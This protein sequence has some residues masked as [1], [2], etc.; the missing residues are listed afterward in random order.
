MIKD[1]QMHEPHPFI[2]MSS[3]TAGE[4]TIRLIISQWSCPEMC[5]AFLNLWPNLEP[6][7]ALLPASDIIS[8]VILWV[9]TASAAAAAYAH[10]LL[11]TSN[12]KG[13]VVNTKAQSQ[14]QHWALI[15]T[16]QIRLE[17]TKRKKWGKNGFILAD[18]HV[19]YI[20][21]WFSL[22]DRCFCGDV[23]CDCI[24]YTFFPPFLNLFLPLLIFAICFLHASTSSQCLVLNLIFMHFHFV[25][26]TLNQAPKTPFFFR[27]SL[28]WFS[29]LALTVSDNLMQ[30]FWPMCKTSPWT[31]LQHGKTKWRWQQADGGLLFCSKN[32]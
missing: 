17:K 26:L 13:N 22:Q 4:N 8:D 10:T 23:I 31:H 11:K 27:M 19:L 28:N 7:S 1:N 32:R 12:L 5:V 16:S 14:H 6:A 15:V 20:S 9:P 30:L 18:G 25:N 3:F 21:F 24:I 29:A 2:S